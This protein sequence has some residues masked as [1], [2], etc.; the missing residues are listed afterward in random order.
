MGTETLI[1]ARTD[2]EAANMIDS[3]FDET[4]QPFILGTTSEIVG[5]QHELADDLVG[6]ESSSDVAALQQEW[7][8]EAALCTYAEAV[9]QHMRKSSD[10][11]L[12]KIDMWEATAPSLG[13]AKAKAFAKR[14]NIDVEPVAWC[15]EKPRTREGYYLMQPGMPPRVRKSLLIP[16]QTR[17]LSRREALRTRMRMSNLRII[18]RRRRRE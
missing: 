16:K 3:N 17:A 18:I 15:C 11:D 2:A 5:P 12:A 1:V 13:W 7:L 10:T 4:D 14:I 9:A 6:D 8:R